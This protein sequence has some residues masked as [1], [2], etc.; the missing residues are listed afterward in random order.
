M[1]GKKKNF[2]TDLDKQIGMFRKGLH[3]KGFVKHKQGTAPLLKN[4][5]TYA[6]TIHKD[7][8]CL[9]RLG[10]ENVLND[11]DVPEQFKKNIEALYRMYE[12]S[13]DIE[14]TFRIGKELATFE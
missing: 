10:F 11:V 9:A 6:E 13:T 14:E 12:I 5:D 4:C 1:P 8:D 7:K 3:K 2:K